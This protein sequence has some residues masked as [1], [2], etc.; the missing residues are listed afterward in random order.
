MPHPDTFI[1]K[2]QSFI[3]AICTNFSYVFSQLVFIGIKIYFKKL[4]FPP[5]NQVWSLLWQTGSEAWVPLGR[6]AAPRMA[7]NAQPTPGQCGVHLQFSLQGRSLQL[8]PQKASLRLPG[9]NSLNISG[10]D[11]LSEDKLLTYKIKLKLWLLSWIRFIQFLILWNDFYLPTL[12]FL[13]ILWQRP[14]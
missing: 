6:L 5:P 13:L 7:D 11:Y 4:T 8:D 2:F 14:S 12:F 3:L 10:L 9:L 1:Q